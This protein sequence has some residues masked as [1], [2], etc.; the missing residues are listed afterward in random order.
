MP[1]IVSNDSVEHFQL[2]KISYAKQTSLTYFF[3][4]IFGSVMIASR[5]VQWWKVKNY[6]W[7]THTVTTCTTMEHWWKMITL[8]TSQLLIP[9]QLIGVPSGQQEYAASNVFM[10][11][12]FWKKNGQNNRLVPLLWYWSPPHLGYL[13]SATAARSLL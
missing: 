3:R 12:Q 13:G 10:F 8:V 2:L 6:E 4:V 11:M 7:S 5:Q 1:L 9:Q